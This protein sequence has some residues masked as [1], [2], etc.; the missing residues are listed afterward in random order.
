M[1]NTKL[2]SVNKLF[3]TPDRIYSFNIHAHYADRSAHPF[4]YNGKNEM[5]VGRAGSTH[6]WEGIGR[7]FKYS[8]RV[9]MNQKIISFWMYPPKEEMEKVIKDLEEALSNQLQYG[10]M[11]VIWD[12][13]EFKIEVVKGLNPKPFST[14]FEYDGLD[15]HWE[16]KEYKDVE[17]IP[18]KN[19]V[20][21]K[22]QSPEE[23]D[24]EHEISPLLKKQ[25]N[26]KGFGAEKYAQKKPIELRQAM[27][28]SENKKEEL[29]YPKLFENPDHVSDGPDD[30]YVVHSYNDISKIMKYDYNNNIYCG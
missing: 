27:Q 1:K 20:G 8:G 13:P 5:K 11:N 7:F 25:R 9:W 29:H 3:E 6:D 23:L 26:V 12:D 16:K 2:I 28:T 15:I 22:D 21:S 4:G 17:I 10:D 19:Y 18:L 30:D 14:E 24:K